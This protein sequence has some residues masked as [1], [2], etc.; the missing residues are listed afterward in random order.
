MSAVET[1]PEKFGF[2]AFPNPSSSRVMLQFRL[3][4]DGKTALSIYDAKGRKVRSLT[5][6]VRSAGWNVVEWDGK[7]DSGPSS[8]RER[9]SRTSRRPRDRRPRK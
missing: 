1:T 3:E 6:Q 5:D 4:R 2:E 9:T 8:A 7:D